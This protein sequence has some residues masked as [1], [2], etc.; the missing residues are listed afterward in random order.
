MVSHGIPLERKGGD[1]EKQS[2][3][4]AAVNRIHENGLR[5]KAERHGN[6][7]MI[8]VLELGRE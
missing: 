5:W 6:Y 2:V 7:L 4:N 1:G 8:S 3:H